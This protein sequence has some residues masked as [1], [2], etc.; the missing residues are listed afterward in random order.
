MQDS[1]NIRMQQDIFKSN[2]VTYIGAM[3]GG[4]RSP[5]LSTKL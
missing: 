4:Y 5:H 1:N 3:G 2:A